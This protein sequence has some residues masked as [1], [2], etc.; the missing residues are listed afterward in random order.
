[1]AKRQLT[2]DEIA[3]LERQGCTAQDW[4]RVLV[5]D[6]FDPDRIR[7]VRFE[8]TVRLGAFTGRLECDDGVPRESGV[9][10]CFLHECSVGDNSYLRDIGC[11]SRYD[12]GERC[13]VEGTRR[14]A[15]TRE[16]SFGN[17]TC[18]SVVN[19]GGGR[20]IPM[21]DRLSAQTAY[22]MAMYRH[23]RVLVER[24]TAM[25]G[26]RSRQL[27]ADR[28]SIGS[29]VW[30]RDSGVLI[31]V[32]IGE[33][34]RVIGVARLE[35]GT[36]AGSAR[37]PVHIGDRGVAKQFVALEGA[38]I[39]GGTRIE[40]CLVGQG[41]RLGKGFTADDC[42]FFANCEGYNGEMCSVF[43]GP[44]TVSHHKSTLLI[45]GIC[46][47]FNAGSAT[48]QSN[49]MYKLGPLHAGVME[50]GCKT[51]SGAYL[52]WPSRIGMFSVVI[53]RHPANID[54]SELP[55]SLVR[56]ENGHSVI[57]PGVGLLGCGVWRDEAKW[58]DRD[59]RAGEH[60]LDIVC[61]DVLTPV[62]VGAIERAVARLAALK[63]KAHGRREFVVWKG[64]R[65]KTRAL[66]SYGRYYRLALHRYL[67][68][69]IAARL[70]GLPADA[71][72]D[73]VRARLAPDVANGAEEWV[74]IAGWVVARSALDELLGGVRDGAVADLD[75]LTARMARIDAG[76][77]SREWTWC[78]EL[79]RRLYGRTAE[80]LDQSH[81][82]EIARNYR[83]A[84]EELAAMVELDA[85]K[86]FGDTASIG[87]GID[88]DERVRER[89][90]AAVRGRPEQHSFFAGLRRAAAEARKRIA[91]LERLAG[92]VDP[93]S[94]NESSPD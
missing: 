30:I 12:I 7:R 59:R 27:R 78:A 44:C 88:G 13:I 81:L 75:E 90:F 50:R 82:A 94:S 48:N 1:M 31:N 76:R 42:V 33:G 11:V 39:G 55:F 24:L 20:A 40:R 87:Y 23:D 19:E 80:T 79:I 56:E 91:F 57:F 65:M 66:E 52:L 62:S 92:G 5:S 6:D 68:E 72:L 54:S 41:V 34:A 10:G 83:Q 64:T 51:G 3:A 22:L 74:D 38:H 70:S 4:R 67:G 21:C 32:L 8:G 77:A 69:K 43:A 47:F 71:S 45:A 93:P 46:S 14:I 53:G 26:A 29:G 28:G 60:C 63:Q 16:T 58:K 25:V 9:Y 84:E 89:D 35:E 85:V 49:H 61:A 73:S 2:H 17:G 86:E 36:V 15:T 18:V 37:D